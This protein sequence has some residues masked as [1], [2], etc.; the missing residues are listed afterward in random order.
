MTIEKIRTIDG[1][2]LLPLSADVLSAL[3]LQ[4]GASVQLTVVDKALVVQSPDVKPANADALQV[5][6]TVLNRRRP[7]Y[8]ELA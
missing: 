6:R 2:S 8:E 4:P 3:G 1:E 7:A 5:F